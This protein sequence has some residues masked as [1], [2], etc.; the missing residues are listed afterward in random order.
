MTNDLVINIRGLKKKYGDKSAVGCVDLSVHRGEIFALL[1]P[2]GAGKTT[3]IK[4]LER[5]RKKSSSEIS[6]L[7]VDPSA[8]ESKD[9][10]RK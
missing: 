8:H 3:T 2:N 7:G 10:E 6:V 4:I 5:Y 9:S 1:G